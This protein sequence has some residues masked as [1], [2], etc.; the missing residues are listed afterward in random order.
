MDIRKVLLN[1]NLIIHTEDTHDI[2]G[3]LQNIGSHYSN[4]DPEGLKAEKIAIE[5]LLRGSG[6]GNFLHTDINILKGIG[7][8]GYFD[9]TILDVLDEILSS[10]SYEAVNDLSEFISRRQE[11]LNHLRQLQGTLQSIGVEE[12][13]ADTYQVVLSLSEQYQDF[14]KLG[15]F[16]ND[17]KNILQRL[18]SKYD[19]AKPVRVSAVNNGSVEF[20]IDVPPEVANL[21][22][23][24][25][26]SAIGVYIAIKSYEKLKAEVEKFS[27]KRKEII[28]DAAKE[29]LEERKKEILNTLIDKL[30]GSDFEAEHKTGIE[31]LLKKWL[32]HLEDGVRLEVKTPRIETKEIKTDSGTEIAIEPTE[33]KIAIDERNRKLFLAQPDELILEL[34]KPDNEEED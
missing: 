24:I 14:D 30:S 28:G 21:V 4:N 31:T 12:D 3:R 17:T 18:N 5:D 13:K 16:L 25:K 23:I 2:Q 32:P 22:S 10:P 27:Q 6:I 34:P 26:E 15:V 1:V 11:L 20:F 8:E 7:V 33:T 29:E 19:D 9:I